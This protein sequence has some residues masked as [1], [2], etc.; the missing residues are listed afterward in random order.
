V[1]LS[2]MA[3]TL[4]KAP[5]TEEVGRR[6]RSLR[7]D[8]SACSSEMRIPTEVRCVTPASRVPRSRSPIASENRRAQTTPF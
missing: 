5:G 4:A 7:P 8:G 2:K 3:P 6:Q 1:E